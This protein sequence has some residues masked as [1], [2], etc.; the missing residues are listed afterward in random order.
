[1]WLLDNRIDP[2]IEQRGGSRT[3]LGQWQSTA[4]PKAAQTWDIRASLSLPIRSTK[5]PT[6]TDSTASSAATHGRGTG[7]L[8]G[9]SSTSLGRPRMVVVHGA[10]SVRPNARIATV[11]E[12][13]TT[14][15][16]GKCGVSHHHTSPRSIAVTTG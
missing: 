14:G 10:T 5:V 3:G 11:L 2:V 7:S 4:T 16:R 6:E 15:R 9:L 12:S 8:S 13:S 1:M